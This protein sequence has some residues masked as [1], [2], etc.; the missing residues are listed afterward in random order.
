M[1]ER[2]PGAQSRRCSPNPDPLARRDL[3]HAFAPR[4]TDRREAAGCFGR[5]PSYSVRFGR[6]IDIPLRPL[7]T[8]RSWTTTPPRLRVVRLDSEIASIKS[9]HARARSL[10]R[11]SVHP[12]NGGGRVTL[13]AGPFSPT[14]EEPT[15]RVLR[16][17]SLSRSGR[18]ASVSTHGRG[19]GSRH[20]MWMRAADGLA[21]RGFDDP[22]FEVVDQV[23]EGGGRYPSSVIR[24]QCV[25]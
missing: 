10:A 8:T 15:R 12:S 23:T 4:L 17:R 13:A 2:R 21:P 20:E 24:Q 25:G 5:N 6:G 7:S 19:E 16:R 14:L 22:M 9:P 11:G 18:V 3:P 1:E